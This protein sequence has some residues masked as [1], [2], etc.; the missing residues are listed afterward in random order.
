MSEVRWRPWQELLRS[1]GIEFVGWFVGSFHCLGSLESHKS[2]LLVPVWTNVK[3]RRWAPIGLYSWC[4]CMT[5]DRMHSERVGLNIDPPDRQIFILYSK[6]ITHAN[7]KAVLSQRW[8]RNA[9][10]TWVPWKFSGLPDYAHGYYS[11]QFSRAFVRIDPLN[12]PTKFEVRIALSVPQI[13]G[14]T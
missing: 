12:V 3:M 9:P 13:I 8:P 7:K 10:Y 5:L 2:S 1:R 14:G 4:S 6:V 11:Q